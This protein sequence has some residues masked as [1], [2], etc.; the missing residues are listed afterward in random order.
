VGNQLQFVTPGDHRPLVY[1]GETDADGRWTDGV[2][3]TEAGDV[4]FVVED[5][6]PRF[7]PDNPSRVDNEEVRTRCFRRMKTDPDTFV[8]RICL[9]SMERDTSKHEE[10]LRPLL[11]IEGPIVEIGAGPGGGATSI[12][13]KAKPDAD[14]VTNDLAFWHLHEWQKFARRQGCWP[15]LRFAQFDAT[16]MPIA[17]DSVPAVVGWRS[18]S[19]CSVDSEKVLREVFRVLRPGGIYSGLE[20]QIEIEL[21]PESPPNAQELFR[22]AFPSLSTDFG[23]LLTRVGFLAVETRPAG[24]EPVTSTKG[25]DAEFAERH[26]VDRYVQ[27]RLIQ[28]RKPERARETRRTTTDRG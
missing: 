6:I 16:R 8:E 2:L 28:G 3:C 13:L 24:R 18:L 20:P 27:W 10:W 17:S 14:I 12:I 19:S 15:N 4:S 9:E 21:T 11:Q 1:E 23:A 26:K 25:K 5:A 7:C 22:E